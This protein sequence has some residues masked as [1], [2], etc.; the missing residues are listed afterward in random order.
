MFCGDFHPSVK[1][2][3]LRERDEWFRRALLDRRRRVKSI[4]DEQRQ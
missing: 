2:I 3:R 1:H 4:G